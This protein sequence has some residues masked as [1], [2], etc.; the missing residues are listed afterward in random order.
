[1]YAELIVDISHEAVDKSFTYRIPES[2][3]LHVGD[4]VL[5]PFGRGKRKGY[6]LSIKETTDYPEEKIREIRSL[7]EKE[8]SVEEELLGLA[9]WM[10]EEY[11]SSLVQCLKTVLPVKKKVRKKT[12]E[13]VLLYKREKTDF[14]LTAEQEKVLHSIQSAFHTGEKEA[15]LFGVTGSGKTE[16]YLRLMEEVIEQGKEVIFLIP[17]ISLSF[18]T[19]SR[20]ERRFPGMVAVLHSR[21]SEGERA[22]SMEKCR[23]GQVKILMGPRS[24]LFAPFSKPGLIIMDEEQDRSY[25]SETSPRYETRELVRMRGILSSCPV[26]YGTATPSLSLFY[27]VEK[28][29]LPCFTL[30]RRAVKGSVLPKTT[31]VDMRKELEEGNRSIFSRLLEEKIRSRL[32]RGEQVMLFMNRRGYAPFVSCRKCGEALRCPH[33][34]VS[35]NLHKD[36]N[37]QCHYCG[38]QMPLP[39]ICPHCGSKYL[40]A[41]G[42]GT[43]KLENLCHSLFPAQEILRMDRDS[44]RKKGMYEEI[45]Q[46]FSEKKAGILIGTQ[47]IVKGHDFPN[48]TLVGIIAADQITLDSDFQAGERAYQLLTQFS[49]R[50]GRGTEEGEVIVQTYQPENPVLKLSL[51]ENYLSFYREEMRYRRRLFYP[52]Y[53]VMLAI[54]LLHTDEIYLDFVLS[55]VTEKLLVKGAE[56][57]GEVYGP[58][59]ATIYK[60]KDKFRKIIYIKHSNHDII[61]RLR[62]YF[63]EELR[64]EDKR[65]LISYHFDLL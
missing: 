33:C 46:R 6:V 37:L 29:E 39:K 22:E 28:G 43:E 13:E 34:D 54:Q 19:R 61:L 62:D 32:K 12:K 17:E 44:T 47:M 27:R 50:A 40:A 52:P 30:T 16:V 31:V 23:S 64:R 56:T 36:G 35:L 59:P 58:F 26:L 8:F 25:K 5:V 11:G 20:I 9:L 15:L 65:G 4:P 10:S 21:M 7:L 41:F 48:V 60:I 63:V 2:M 3:V 57:E 49:G 24:A 53:A 14:S 18:Q 51:Q 42:T 38:F 1:M 45:L 55:K